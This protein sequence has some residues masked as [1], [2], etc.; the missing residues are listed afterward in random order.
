MFVWLV[1]AEFSFPFFIS[2]YIALT[3]VKQK[4]FVAPADIDS[5]P[6][7]AGRM[8]EEGRRQRQTDRQTGLTDGKALCC[9]PVKT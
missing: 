9:I 1:G 6:G 5:T 4:T 7:T 8:M 2:C 3:G